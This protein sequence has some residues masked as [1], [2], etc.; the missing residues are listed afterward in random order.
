MKRFHDTNIWDKAWFDDLEP[1]QKLLWMY[2]KDACDCAG[3][4]SP[5]WRR[6][7][8]CVG[9][10]VGPDDLVALGSERVIVLPNRKVW[11]VA[12]VAFQ[13]GDLTEKCAPHRRVLEALRRNAIDLHKY[14]TRYPKPTLPGTLP[15]RVPLTLEEEEE[16]EEEEGKGDARGKGS[17]GASTPD[18]AADLPPNLSVG[19]FPAVWADWVRYRRRKG[20]VKD[21]PDLFSRQLDALAKYPDPIPADTLRQSMQNGW[22]GIFPE[23]LAPNE[24]HRP[25]HPNRPDRN[26]GTTNATAAGDYSAAAKRRLE[27]RERERES[28]RKQSL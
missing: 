7:S 14:P 9:Q 28:A 25:T 22:T 3:V 20:G 26:A 23:K 27:E 15:P 19:E 12:F 2:L 10:K 16:E 17:S 6:A 21:W 4:W 11:L 18:P 5:N 8:Y 1:R 24:N 13:Y